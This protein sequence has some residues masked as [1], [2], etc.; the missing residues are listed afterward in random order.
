MYPTSDG[1]MNIAAMGSSMFSRLCDV[2]EMPEMVADPRFREAGLRVENR[3]AL[4][5]EIIARTRTRTTDEWISRLNAA[6]VPCGPILAMDGVFANEQVRH[7]R[8]TREVDTPSKGKI[9]IMAPPLVFSDGDYPAPTPAPETGAHTDEILQWL[10]VQE[11]D[12]QRLRA[13][14]AL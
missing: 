2:L 3:E 5:R 9:D 12:R 7:L 11:A 14:G 8:M 4:N 10:G 1:Y 13:A 6:G